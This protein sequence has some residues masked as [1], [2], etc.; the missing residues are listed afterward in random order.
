MSEIIDA[1]TGI[2][3]FHGR[4]SVPTLSRSEKLCRINPLNFEGWNDLILATPGYSFFHSAN[5]AQVLIETYGYSPCYYALLRENKLAVLLPLMQINSRITGKRAVCLPFSDYCF[6]IINGSIDHRKFL[7]QVITEG[8]K[9]HWKY[10]EIRGEELSPQ[11]ILPSSVYYRHTLPLA[12]GEEQIYS[13]LRSN[14]RSK[15][16][17]AENN[18]VK[19]NIYRS[20]EA[21]EEYYRLHCKTR[22]RHGFPPQPLR[23]FRKI[24]EHIVSQN[25][26]FMA[27]AS[28]KSRTIAGAVYFQFG[29]QAIYKFGASDPDYQHLFANYLIMWKAIRWAFQNEYREFCFGKTDVG[30]DGLIQFKDGWGADKQQL[31]Y[32][33][34]NLKTGRFLQDQQ[35]SNGRGYFIFRKMPIPILKMAGNLLYRHIG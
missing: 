33:R 4:E 21:L 30:Q 32:Y 26:G 24:N 29:N 12:A 28:L 31:K 14:Y 9:A 35:T 6:P 7:Q 25:L 8:K 5:W 23:F 15:L 19:V 20:P 3:D 18:G 34:Y 11:G 13:R 1:T 22:K 17:K 2:V 27:L 16:R 10:I